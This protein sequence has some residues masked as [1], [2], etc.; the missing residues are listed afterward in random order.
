MKNLALMLLIGIIILGIGC[1]N[2]APEAGQDQPDDAIAQ[3][4]GS[5]GDDTPEVPRNKYGLPD[6]WSVSLTFPD[7][8]E[9]ISVDDTSNETTDM[10]NVTAKGG[11][12]MEEIADFYKNLDGWEVDTEQP[13]EIRDNFQFFKINCIGTG[14]H[15]GVSIAVKPAWTEVTLM[16]VRKKA[17]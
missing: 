1:T 16:F 4:D 11:L 6:A 13:E 2:T 12:T 3:A 14:E 7:G 17:V 10:L 15:S 8:F 5:D 9:I